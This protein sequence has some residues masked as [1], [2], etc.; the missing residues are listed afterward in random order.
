MSLPERIP[1]SNIKILGKII[2]D[3]KRASA[4]NTSGIDFSKTYTASIVEVCKVPGK[5]K[6]L[7][8]ETDNKGVYFVYKIDIVENFE[9]QVHA[10]G[11]PSV[12]SAPS[13]ILPD[14]VNRGLSANQLPQASSDAGIDVESYRNIILSL[15]PEALFLKS[16]A[17]PKDR[18]ALNDSVV[19]MHDNVEGRYYITEVIGRSKT[20]STG[21]NET[22]EEETATASSAFDPCAPKKKKKKTPQTTEEKPPVEA[23]KKSY[24]PPT[25]N[26]QKVKKSAK[27]LD[28]KGMT[29]E[30]Y[31]QAE[32]RIF[33]KEFNEEMMNATA[34]MDDY[35]RLRR[36]NL[37]I[38][39]YEK[40]KKDASWRKSLP[41]CGEVAGL[42]TTTGGTGTNSQ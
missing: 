35:E 17:T 18:P 24:R 26:G 25:T 15:K 36:E 23:P 10:S 11:I 5:Q 2:E 8:I 31:Y 40:R 13:F 16:Q 39:K 38:Q 3:K 42:N 4:S 7:E 41:S 28:R 6:L 32:I 20:S 34:A 19:V 9:T 22:K 33:E 12:A 1:S 29:P 37:A 21:G 27:C 30:K 14:S